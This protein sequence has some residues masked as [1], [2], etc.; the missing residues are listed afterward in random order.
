MWV[1]EWIREGMRALQRK[2]GLIQPPSF[3][4]HTIVDIVLDLA[5][6][7]PKR[8]SILDFCFLKT[9]FDDKLIPLTMASRE[10]DNESISPNMLG[11]IRGC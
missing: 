1:K 2:S 9:E 4:G 7:F 5:L 10:Q 6:H 3:N 8:N 11:I